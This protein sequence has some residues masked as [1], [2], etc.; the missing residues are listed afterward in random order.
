ML[1]SMTGIMLSTVDGQFKTSA[2]SL[3]NLSY[4]LLGYLPAPTVYGLIYDA[5][6][7]GNARIA[8]AT[9]MFT[10][11][12]SLICI[13]SAA[14]ILIKSDVLQYKKQEEERRKYEEKVLG[15]QIISPSNS[16]V[17]NP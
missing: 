10:P 15:E 6:D 16:E 13:L 2:N 4:N 1:P 8:M 17:F 5:G 14:Y 3:A 9:L 11:S 7:G 12:I